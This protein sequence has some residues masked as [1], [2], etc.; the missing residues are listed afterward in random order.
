MGE[1][2]VYT[3][4]YTQIHV[5]SLATTPHVLG[6]N[7]GSKKIDGH[8]AFA[9]YPKTCPKKERTARVESNVGLKSFTV[10]LIRMI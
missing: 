1:G 2:I 7:L 9:F 6:S 4:T 10:D 3:Y 5:S 8:R